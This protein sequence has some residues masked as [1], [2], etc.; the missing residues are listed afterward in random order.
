[1]GSYYIIFWILQLSLTWD[2][3]VY[4][5]D[6]FWTVMDMDNV[7]TFLKRLKDDPIH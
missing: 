4:P 2:V 3:N 1:M 5:I 7:V 6:G